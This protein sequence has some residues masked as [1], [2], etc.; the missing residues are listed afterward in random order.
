MLQQG[1][2]PDVFAY[3]TVISACGKGRM[4]IKALLL[5]GELR[6]LGV[7]PVVITCNAAFSACGKT[8]MAMKAMQLFGDGAP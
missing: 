3:S 4:A 7:Q 5:L 8:G 2:Q 1:L 6:Q